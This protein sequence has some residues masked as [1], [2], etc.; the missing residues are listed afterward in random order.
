MKKRKTKSREKENRRQKE[1]E[2]HEKGK[3]NGIEE[4]VWFGQ[5]GAANLKGPLKVLSQS[6][7]GLCE[8]NF[9]PF[10]RLNTERNR[11]HSF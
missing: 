6:P 1:G 8:R 4:K 5:R 7:P 3:G 10:R 9:L 11:V 2:L